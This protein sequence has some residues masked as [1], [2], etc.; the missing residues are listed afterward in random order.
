MNAELRPRDNFAK[1]FKRAETAGQSDKS[2]GEFR[3]HRF[4][5][6]IESTTRS[7]VKL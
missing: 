2:V 4:A 3:H 5:L 6:C 7:S 1:L